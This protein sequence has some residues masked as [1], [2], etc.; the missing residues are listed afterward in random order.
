GDPYHIVALVAMDLRF[1]AVLLQRVGLLPAAYRDQRI[2]VRLLA[3]KDAHVAEA[4]KGVGISR[5]EL[6]CLFEIRYGRAGIAD[7]G[8]CSADIGERPADELTRHQ[9]PF[10]RLL[11][12]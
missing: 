9:L 3:M 8:H 7:G 11:V 6:D 5:K 4:D 1:I 12:V 10:R 2:D